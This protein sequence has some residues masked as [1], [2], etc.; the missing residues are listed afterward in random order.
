M[1]RAAWVVQLILVCT[2]ALALAGWFWAERH[3]ANQEARY[4][5]LLASGVQIP[6]Q[7]LPTRPGERWVARVIA[8][9]VSA[10]AVVVVARL[11]MTS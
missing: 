2:S 9:V 4:Q 7:K 1:E 6:L 11:V 10:I 8:I 5:S 3:Y